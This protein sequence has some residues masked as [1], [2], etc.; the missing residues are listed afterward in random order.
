MEYHVMVVFRSFVILKLHWL[1]KMDL[2]LNKVGRHLAC[3]H[4]K[5]DLKLGLNLGPL[6]AKYLDFT[7]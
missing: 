6:R 2:K 4:P 3:T 5:M 1:P 7:E